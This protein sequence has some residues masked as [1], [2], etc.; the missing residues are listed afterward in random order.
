MTQ[1]EG[2]WGDYGP[3]KKNDGAEPKGQKQ[4]PVAPASVQP[5]KPAATS[6]PVTIK[7]LKIV[8]KG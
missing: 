5:A 6:A 1:I 8:R 3:V 4:M 2:W 7:P